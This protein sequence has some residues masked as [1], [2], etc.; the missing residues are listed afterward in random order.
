MRSG[1]VAIIPRVTTTIYVNSLKVL[2]RQFPLKLGYAITVHAAQGMTLSRVVF[3][4]RAPVFAHGQM[5]VA[6]SRVQKT[7]GLLILTRPVSVELDGE[8]GVSLSNILYQ[9]FIKF[10]AGGQRV[11]HVSCNAYDEREDLPPEPMD[12]AHAQY[13]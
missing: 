1:K 11:I 6:L 3:N 13:P 4:T 10:A 7:Q 2:R 9:P 8:R 12:I 5:Y